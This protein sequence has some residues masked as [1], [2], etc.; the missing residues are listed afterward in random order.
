[1]DKCT[2]F[3]IANIENYIIIMF[4]EKCVE[5]FAKGLDALGPIDD[6]RADNDIEFEIFKFAFN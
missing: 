1:M 2:S 3:N 6:I 4:C 5:N